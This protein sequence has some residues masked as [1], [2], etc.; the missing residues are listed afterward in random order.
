MLKKIQ[1]SDRTR[2]RFT[3]SLARGLEVYT[4]II[5]EVFIDDKNPSITSSIGAGGRY[6]KI[7]GQLIG[8]NEEYP[9]VGMTFGVDVIMEVLKGN[10]GER[11]STN[12]EYLI[13]PMK[14]F[15]INALQYANELRG[16][17]LKV[18]VDLS[19]KKIKKSMNVANKLKIPF[20]S[21]YGE[22]E[23]EKG[24]IRIKNMYNG[25]EKAFKQID[26]QDISSFIEKQLKVVGK[27]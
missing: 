19:G 15:E 2:Y 8:N 1:A 4:G 16:E 5:W 24:E 20:V 23:M 26:T 25:V 13:I 7:I 27:N 21:V 6:D 22:D 12:V 14:G 9:A 18:D 17:Q 10:Q 3:P 11:V